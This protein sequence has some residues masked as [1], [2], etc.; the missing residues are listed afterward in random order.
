[1]LYVGHALW[2]FLLDVGIPWYVYSDFGIC[3]L[4]TDPALLYWFRPN[5]GIVLN[6][7]CGGSRERGMDG[8]A[9]WIPRQE[10]EKD[11]CA[12]TSM[13]K[14]CAVPGA[15]WWALLQRWKIKWEYRQNNNNSRT[16][17]P[18]QRRLEK[19]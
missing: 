2:H 15:C 4:T 10:R 3:L 13:V 6:C 5:L 9:A 19:M 17:G 16:Q 7:C 14:K 18:S 12:I 1:M 11:Q 8:P